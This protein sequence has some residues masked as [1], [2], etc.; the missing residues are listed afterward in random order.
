MAALYETDGGY[1]HVE[2]AIKAQ[3]EVALGLGAE[4]WT[5][6]EV[7]GIERST[8]YVTLQ[9]SR[10]PVHA[11]HV[12]CSAGPWSHQVLGDLA[13][14]LRVKRKVLAWFA[15]RPEQASLYQGSQGVSF[16]FEMPDGV[17]YGFPSLDGVTLKVAS[18]DD[19]H[20]IEGPDQIERRLQDDDLAQVRAFATNYLV[21]VNPDQVLRHAVCMYTMT[22][23]LHMVVDHHPADERIWYAAGLSGHGFKYSNALGEALIQLA[24]EGQSVVDL[25]G[26]RAARFSGE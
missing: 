25:S 1:L 16:L 12:V 15:L 7:M 19:G 17:V 20:F 2:E 8:A 11:R 10:G 9:T 23:D 18:H 13:L 4:L 26:F 21:G 6:T 14:P 5:G 3:C 24:T 22:P